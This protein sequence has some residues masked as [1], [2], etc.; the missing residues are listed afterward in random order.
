MADVSADQRIIKIKEMLKMFKNNSGFTLIEMLIVLSIISVL[1]ILIVPNLGKSNQQVHDQ[2]CDALVT[3]VQSQVYL[4]HLE[5]GKYPDKLSDLVDDDFITDDQTKC[6][7][8]ETL[9]L[10]NGIVYVH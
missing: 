9:H 4:Y 7:N 5:K 6:S 1:I 8:G 3:V 10:E 2:G